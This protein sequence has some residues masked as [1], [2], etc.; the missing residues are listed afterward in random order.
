VNGRQSRLAEFFHGHFLRSV[1]FSPQK[2]ANPRNVM[3]A[4]FVRLRSEEHAVQRSE[5]ARKNSSS[6]DFLAQSFAFCRQPY[7][8]M[9]CNDRAV[10]AWFTLISGRMESEI[11]LQFFPQ[12]IDKRILLN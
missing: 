9:A 10:R 1:K 11:G 8:I 7:L 6:N 5:N 3:R 4:G 2:R 12:P